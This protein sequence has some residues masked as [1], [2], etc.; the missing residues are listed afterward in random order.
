M[1]SFGGGGN[2]WQINFECGAMAKLAI[3]PDV[4]A[5]LLYDAV[6]RGEAQARAFA[7]FLGSEEGFE[8]AS[9]SLSVH[10]AAVIGD[11]EHYIGPG[12][13]FD[14]RVLRGVILVNFNA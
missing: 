13:Q 7:G 1:G 14:D 10:A 6:Y 8:D 9:L 12:F 3:D 2:S 11:G 4:A 5:A